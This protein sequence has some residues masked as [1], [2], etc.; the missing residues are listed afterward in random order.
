MTVSIAFTSMSIQQQDNSDINPS[1][2]V[3]TKEN[4]LN[5]LYA[6]HS[7]RWFQVQVSTRQHASALIRC[8]RYK[9]KTSI[10]W[11]SLSSEVRKMIFRI[12]LFVY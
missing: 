4:C 9:T 12:F 2:Q 11:K 1:E 6:M 10:N 8:L 3:L 5:A 7:V